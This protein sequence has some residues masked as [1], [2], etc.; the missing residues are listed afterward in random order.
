MFSSDE[1][2]YSICINCTYRLDTNKTL[3]NKIDKKNA[4]ISK[5]KRI[6]YN[7]KD[8]NEILIEALKFY[9]HTTSDIN[10]KA[11]QTLKEC[12][13]DWQLNNN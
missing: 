1:D 13:I 2:D 7:L 11:M 5:Q 10:Y 9:C 3:R 12:G 4:E 8:Q 6:N